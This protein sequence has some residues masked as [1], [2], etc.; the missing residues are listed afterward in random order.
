MIRDTAA[1]QLQMT[2]GVQ[3][4]Q[5]S[6][7]LLLIADEIVASLRDEDPQNQSQ[8]TNQQ[9][10]TGQGLNALSGLETLNL[11]GQVFATLGQTQMQTEALQIN[12]SN[13]SLFAPAGPKQVIF[14]GQTL[15]L[16]GD[17][18]IDGRQGLLQAMGGV[19]FESAGIQFSGDRIQIRPGSMT[20]ATTD[21]TT[22]PTAN[23]NPQTPQDSQDPGMLPEIL[24]EG[25]IRAQGPDFLL[26]AGRI[27]TAPDGQTIHFSGGLTFSG[28]QGNLRAGR[29]SF[30]I[31]SQDFILDQASD[32]PIEGLV[33][34]DL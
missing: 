25:N 17:V 19:Q 30:N 18:R 29:A 8:T 31:Q 9:Q 32:E 22:S 26:T 15:N 27:E 33:F 2:G 13:Q 10:Q 14:N 7:G 11:Q 16:S 24:I 20:G 4:R 3:V 12:I 28:D 23:Q 5:E 21:A 6:Q 1:N 34:V